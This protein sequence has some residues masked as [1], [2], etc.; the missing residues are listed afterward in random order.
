MVL[1]GSMGEVES[2]NVHA[3]PQKLSTIGTDLEAGPKVQTIFVLGF[4]SIRR[5]SA[6]PL[7]IM[8]VYLNFLAK[9]L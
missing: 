6:S 5:A 9:H 1:V 8:F 4:F 2:S 3:S 7:F